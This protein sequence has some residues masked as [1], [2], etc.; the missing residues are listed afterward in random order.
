MVPAHLPAVKRIFPPHAFFDEG[1]P[2]LA[3]HRDSPSFLH[4]LNGIPGEAG[5]MDNLSSRVPGQERLG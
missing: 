5:V 4:H 3:H 2:S 1:M